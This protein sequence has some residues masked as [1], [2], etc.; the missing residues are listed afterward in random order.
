MISID[1]SSSTSSAGWG[2]GE[3]EGVVFLKYT[4]ISNF[5]CILIK[6][7]KK[8][9]CYNHDLD[10][11]TCNLWLNG[12]SKIGSYLG[13]SI[14]LWSFVLGLKMSRKDGFAMKNKICHIVSEKLCKNNMEYDI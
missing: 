11:Q 8:Y 7:L 5:F 6:Y 9:Q 2:L 4:I 13:F 12:N 10:Y 3:S 1:T 14:S